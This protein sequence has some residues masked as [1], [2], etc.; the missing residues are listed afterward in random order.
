[1]DVYN[2]SFY[3]NNVFLQNRL[4]TQANAPFDFLLEEDLPA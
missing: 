1:M 3:A 2:V 4:M